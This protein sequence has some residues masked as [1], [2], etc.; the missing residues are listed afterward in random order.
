MNLQK[1]DTITCEGIK[2]NDKY[3]FKKLYQ[4]TWPEEKKR[5]DAVT[6]LIQ[7]RVPSIEIEFVGF[8]ANTTEFIKEHPEESGK[9]DLSLQINEIEIIALEV[10]GTKRMKAGEGYWVRPDKLE[11]IQNHPERDIW[12]VLHYQEPEEKFVWIKP[13]IAKSY[14]YEEKNLKGVTERY[15]IFHDGQK[16]VKKTEDVMTYMQTKIKEIKLN[17]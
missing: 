4:D 3:I 5:I 9:P 17:M 13:D 16:E 14:P 6:K 2:E 7:Q 12:I 10:T 15:V 1:G 8:G 11:Y